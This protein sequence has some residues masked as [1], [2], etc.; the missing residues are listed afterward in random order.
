MRKIISDE[1]LKSIALLRA[2]VPSMEFIHLCL[3]SNVC[4][5]KYISSALEFI[6]PRLEFNYAKTPIARITH[7]FYTERDKRADNKSNIHNRD[8]RKVGQASGVSQWKKRI[9]KREWWRE[10]ERKRNQIK[11]LSLWRKSS[12]ASCSHKAG[13]SLAVKA[14]RH[15]ERERASFLCARPTFQFSRESNPHAR[16]SP[17]EKS[18]GFSAETNYVRGEIELWGR[19]R[20]YELAFEKALQ[21]TVRGRRF[22]FPLSNLAFVLRCSYVGRV[23]ATL[24]RTPAAIPET[25][26]PS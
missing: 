24:D 11:A 6:A 13:W 2:K 26:H 17:D 15:R 18:L 3:I 7:F 9:S 22:I 10:R 21:A 16:G 1:I 4:R 8:E 5:S 25:L 23:C 20:S 12:R 19:T 14:R